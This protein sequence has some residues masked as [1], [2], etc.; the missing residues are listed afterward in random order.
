MSVDLIQK[1]FL[2]LSA[3][4]FCAEVN[5]A[6]E[7]NCATQT[8][9]ASLKASMNISN[10]RQLDIGGSDEFQPIS[11]LAVSAHI[12]RNSD[13]T[14]GISEAYLVNEM[15]KVNTAFLGAGLQFYIDQIYYVNNSQLYDF[16]SSEE[17][18]LANS[19]DVANTINIYFVERIAFVVGTACGYAYLPNNGPDRIIISETCGLSGNTLAH[20]FGH[21]FNLIHT[22]GPSN[23]Y[24]STD[25]LVDGSNCNVAGD[26]VCDTPA[27]PVLTNQV[28]SS[29]E[30]VGTFLDG[31]QEPFNPDTRNLL[32]YSRGSCRESMTNGQLS[33]VKEALTSFRSYIKTFP[34][35]SNFQ[36]DNRKIC[37]EEEV[38]FTD[39]SVGGSSWEWIFEGGQPAVSNQQHP[40]VTYD[41]PGNF[42]VSLKVTGAGG[43]D[44]LS[45]ENYVIVRPTAHQG[46]SILMNLE[47]ISSISEVET[48]VDGVFEFDL[49]NDYSSQGSKSIWINSFANSTNGESIARFY[50]PAI[51]QHSGGDFLLQF[52]MAYRMRPGY[53]DRLNISSES[54]CDRVGSNIYSESEVSLSGNEI[55]ENEFFPNNIDWRTEGVFITVENGQDP[56]NIV[57]ESVSE[58]GNNL[59]IDNIRVRQVQPIDEDSLILVQ[60]YESFDGELPWD[61]RERV[62]NWSGVTLSQYSKVTSLDFSGL[63]LNKE[64]PSLLSQL[65]DLDTLIL[66]HNNFG[67]LE[68]LTELEDL[69]V[70]SISDNDL[71]TLPSDWSMMS[72]LRDLNLRNNQIVSLPASLLNLDGI[73]MINVRNNRIVFDGSQQ[74]APS[75]VYLDLSAN[76]LNQNPSLLP[77]DNQ[78]LINLAQNALTISS[79]ID[80]YRSLGIYSP[81]NL[82]GSVEYYATDESLELVCPISESLVSTSVNWYRNNE[83]ILENS[84]SLLVSDLSGSYY[85]CETV[86]SIV[87][88][89]ELL[90]N[91]FLVNTPK[92]ICEQNLS[93]TYQATTTYTDADDLTSSV[94]SEITL[95]TTANQLYEI[96]D[97]SFGVED[98][99][100]SGTELKGSST[101]DCGQFFTPISDY[102]PNIIT[103]THVDVQSGNVSLD[104]VDIRGGKGET[105]LMLDAPGLSNETDIL[106]FSFSSQSA[107]AEIDSFNKSIV[108]RV[109]CKDF[110]NIPTFELSAGASAYVE[111]ELQQ[112]A[113]SAQDFN[114]PVTY[115][116][117]AEDGATTAEWVVT[118]L[119]DPSEVGVNFSVDNQTF[120]NPLNGAISITDITVDGLSE[121][122][123]L[124]EFEIQW[125]PDSDFENIIG[126][127]LSIEGLASGEYFLRVA[128]ISSGCGIQ[129]DQ[130]VV[131]DQTPSPSL[132]I[133]TTSADKSCGGINTGSITTT[134]DGLP[135][136]RVIEWDY[137][138]GGGW[139]SID[140]FDGLTV[141]DG[142]TSGLYRQLIRDQ[143][144]GCSFTQEAIIQSQ[145]SIITADLIVAPE[146]DCSSPNGSISIE[147]II[148]DGDIVEEPDGNYSY[149]WSDHPDLENI[150]GSSISLDNL[151]AGNYYLKIIENNLLC[152]SQTYSIYVPANTLTANVLVSSKQ[153]NTLCS[154]VERN[155][156]I[157][158]TVDGSTEGYAFEWFSGTN[159]SV[160]PFKTGP[161]ITQMPGGVYTAKVTSTSGSEQ[162][163]YTTVTASI[164]NDIDELD[165]SLRSEPNTNCKSP[166]GQV[167][168]E[169]FTVDGQITPI[170]GVYEIE[171]STNRFFGT[172]LSDK[173]SVPNLA[174]MQYFARVI[175]TTTG[176]KTSTVSVRVNDEL[177]EIDPVFQIDNNSHCTGPFTGVIQISNLEPLADYK[178][179]WYNQSP[180]VQETPISNGVGLENLRS[181]VYYTIVEDLESGCTEQFEHL[182]E[183][184]VLSPEVEV[185][186][187]SQTNCTEPNGRIRIIEIN[188]GLTEQL[189]DNYEIE[190]STTE[191]FDVLLSSD[192]E[193]NGLTSGVYYLRVTNTITGCASIIYNFTVNDST[194][195]PVID[196]VG[197]SEERPAYGDL[198]ELIVEIDSEDEFTLTWYSSDDIG[199]TVLS[200]ESTVS[201]LNAGL[202]S[203]L[204]E[205]ENQCSTLAE[206]EVTKDDR[207]LQEIELNVPSEV[208]VNSEAIELSGTSTSGLPVSYKVESG[209]GRISLGKLIITGSG[210]IVISGSVQEND[211]FFSAQSIETILVKPLIELSGNVT[212]ALS[213]VV[214]LYN[215]NW[216]LVDQITFN[217]SVYVIDGIVPGQ[218]YLE[219]TPSSGVVV[220][221]TYHPKAFDWKNAE[222]LEL[223]SDVTLNLE[224]ITIPEFGQGSMLDVVIIEGI[225]NTLLTLG[226][227]LEG[228]EPVRNMKLLLLEANS[229][230]V[231]SV[232]LSDINGH[233]ILGPVPSGNYFLYIDHIGNSIDL[234]SVLF[235]VD[236]IANEQLTLE[237]GD[238]DEV[239]LVVV[240]GI[241]DW[242][243]GEIN[244]FPNPVTNELN[245]GLERGLS[246]PVD[247]RVFN[248]AGAMLVSEIIAPGSASFQLPLNS[249]PSGTYLVQLSDS[250]GSITKKIIKR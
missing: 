88:E 136:D 195:S 11:R 16:S 201:D 161:S 216:E 5:L 25:E 1:L 135:P 6:Q 34:V 18:T 127:G 90:S 48:E 242:S 190:W 65:T 140:E 20:E 194:V 67:G 116:V 94:N 13:G 78:T 175:N 119:E 45:F 63:Q 84:S 60:I 209:P 39:L 3:V 21:F 165:V 61:V 101:F 143:V 239:E 172:V 243:S 14:G 36:A 132:T 95:T 233:L 87:P 62:E 153:D 244:L 222:L 178:V 162:G 144:S 217:G 76:S 152:E 64:L 24:N 32:S 7:L 46:Q 154:S 102:Y 2:S 43:E 130:I 103:S 49:N 198:G 171:W 107:T 148:K 75:L 183:D 81:Q 199:G 205:T 181:G 17:G 139:V 138:D 241:N 227:L 167:E 228:T 157:S 4:L 230:V 174:E 150:I 56:F 115:S 166:N 220:P 151:R 206:F 137:N 223:T 180:D 245:V 8:D 192:L 226:E 83:L 96:S 55:A 70:L 28:N 19:R 234:S 44:F 80:N 224:L 123:D 12:V 117:I 229:N 41:I 213:G 191:Q 188:E 106:S 250:K 164:I 125:S 141:L 189:V 50:T 97:L 145:P 197:M 33:R 221:R 203:V 177:P 212:G 238:N 79:I 57:F 118:L 104:W 179:S 100:Y 37:Q 23:S 131:L 30:Y 74:L 86:D 124:E 193:V 112:S 156:A 89:V 160:S 35:Q 146:S 237:L 208:F 232:G 134:I 249:L 155:G 85:Q 184:Q 170:S 173:K 247:L 225:G 111:G 142:L 211:L 120:C 187:I 31:N 246:Y 15:E 52:D 113:S 133:E 27:D 168:I 110:S 122:A 163:C 99:V 202:Y 98:Q 240:S 58:G 169:A 215:V 93:G 158:L 10:A 186:I 147:N 38:H 207:L 218:Y 196:L 66:D 54:Y 9:I 42:S 210:E 149:Q 121:I 105:I 114:Q 231:V 159:I 129:V 26:L 22:H 236:G 185:E 82:I 214:K 51:T 71:V 109:G 73:E 235:S 59:Y 176:C 92:S 53:S 68:I 128:E 248:L 72:G 40:S 126:D 200:N 29:C 47:D 108:L 69:S 77:Q 182:V 219:A 91:P 204:V